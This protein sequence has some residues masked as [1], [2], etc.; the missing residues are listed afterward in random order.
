MQADRS[1]HIHIDETDIN[2]LLM[3]YEIFCLCLEWDRK[4]RDE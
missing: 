1:P 3:S 4:K 2:L